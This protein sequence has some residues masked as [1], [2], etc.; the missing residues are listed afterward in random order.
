MLHPLASRGSI[1]ARALMAR[2][3]RH[4][5]SSTGYHSGHV[6]ITR[7]ETG[8][9]VSITTHPILVFDAMVVEVVA[10][11]PECGLSFQYTATR[12]G[13]KEGSWDWD[14]TIEPAQNLLTPPCDPD[15]ELSCPDGVVDQRYLRSE[16]IEVSAPGTY[17]L[18]V[19]ADDGDICWKEASTQV[20]V[21][22]CP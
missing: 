19:N 4:E 6:V 9:S 7:I 17:T 12:T 20:V 5:F 18:T 22:A 8:A 21:R 14:A 1:D 2:A 11:A 3:K 15:N 10:E 13:G 16:T